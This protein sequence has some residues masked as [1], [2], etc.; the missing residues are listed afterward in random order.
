MAKLRVWRP[1]VKDGIVCA[2][3]LA[4]GITLGAAGQSVDAAVIRPAFYSAIAAAVPVVLL[5]VVVHIR[6]AGGALVAVESDRAADMKS[7]SS[8][9][10]QLAVLRSE[11]VGEDPEVGRVDDL[12]ARSEHL[13][14]ELGRPAVSA[15]VPKLRLVVAFVFIIAA[16]SEGA[17]LIALGSGRS[18]ALT[19]YLAAYSLLG[20]FLLL[21]FLEA[22]AVAVRAGTPSSETATTESASR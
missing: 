18:T 20:Q 12:A 22:D 9:L 10:D 14:A 13:L 11:V 15:G 2:C 5:A 17:C 19:F 4:A 6:S 21:A 7:L 8:I 16:V 1:T 3:V